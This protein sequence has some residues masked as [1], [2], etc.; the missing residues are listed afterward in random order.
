[1]YYIQAGD[2]EYSDVGNEA[3]QLLI[4]IA[5]LAAWSQIGPLEKLRLYIESAQV[6]VAN[7]ALGQADALIKA[8]IVLVGEVPNK[9]E[10]YCEAEV[11]QAIEAFWMPDKKEMCYIYI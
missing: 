7:Q 2:Q 11:D 8:A 4:C 5:C 6:A 1:M 9:M 10:V 3:R